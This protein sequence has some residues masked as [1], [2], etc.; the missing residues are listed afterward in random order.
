MHESAD[1]IYE[2]IEN[3]K[4]D[5]A[6]ERDRAVRN[7]D[8][9]SAE[10]W[11][12]CLDALA[13]AA[14]SIRPLISETMV[15]AEVE[16]A[17][18]PNR[19]APLAETENLTSD[20][21]LDASHSADQDHRVTIARDVLIV[22]LRRMTRFRKGAAARREMTLLSFRDGTLT[23]SI[24]NVSEHLPADG[25]WPG[26]IIANCGILYNLAKVPPIEDPVVV[27]VDQ[28]Q[29]YIGSAATPVY[30]R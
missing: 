5:C 21:D 24:H 27:R 6:H 30:I 7:W 10:C 18:T 26:D 2:L 9:D 20:S 29:L 11:Q 25:V 3:A 17:D 23:F 22:A 8:K 16:A 1:R 19:L 28:D 15:C 12:C 14:G 13:A 4:T